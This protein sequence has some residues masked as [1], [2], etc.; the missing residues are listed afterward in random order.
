MKAQDI[1][2]EITSN[3]APTLSMRLTHLP[4][5]IVVAG[6]GIGQYVLRKRLMGMLGPLVE[7]RRQMEKVSG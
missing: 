1:K 3:A 4:T 6:S 2:Q 5:G 7:A